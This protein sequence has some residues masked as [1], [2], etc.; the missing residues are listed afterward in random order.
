M[1]KSKFGDKDA[2]YW[3]HDKG[4]MTWDAR[5]RIDH[6]QP[7]WYFSFMGRREKMLAWQ[8]RKS[9]FWGS[10]DEP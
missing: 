2:D 7:T 8:G 9:K 6:G 1:K 3:R 5:C 4:D 10:D